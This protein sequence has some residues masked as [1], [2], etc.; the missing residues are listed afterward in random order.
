[1]C[2]KAHD[3]AERRA[4]TRLLP[5]SGRRNPWLLLIHMAGNYCR[6][7]SPNICPQNPGFD[8]PFCSVTSRS[9]MVPNKTVK[10]LQKVALARSPGYGERSSPSRH[11]H[12]KL[13]VF[14]SKGL[15]LGS[16]LSVEPAQPRV[17]ELRGTSST[18][19]GPAAQKYSSLKYLR[20]KRSCCKVIQLK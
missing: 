14:D 1:M 5:T 18:F 6:R 17:Q 15:V 8:S 13:W 12:G 11:D 19:R 16:V 20:F 4:R 7:Q 2:Q 10:S 3:W 9:S